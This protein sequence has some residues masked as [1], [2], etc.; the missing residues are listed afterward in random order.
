MNFGFVLQEEWDKDLD[1][2]RQDRRD[3]LANGSIEGFE[4]VHA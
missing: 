2:W 4:F 3:C 1:G